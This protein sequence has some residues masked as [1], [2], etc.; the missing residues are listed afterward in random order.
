MAPSMITSDSTQPAFAKVPASL[1]EEYRQKLGTNLELTDAQRKRLT[2]WLK[3]SLDGWQRDT[4][5]LHQNLLD[6][7]DLVEG[8]VPETSFPWDGAS[9]VH[10]PITEMYMEIFE[11]VEKRSILGADLIWYAETDDED[12]KDVTADVEDAL[13]FKARN[14]WNICRSIEQVFPTTNRD[15]LGLLE[16]TWCEEYEKTHDIVLIT[17][18]DE[19]IQ[20][21]PDPESAGVTDEEYKRWA[22][23]SLAATDEEPMEIPITFE[24]EVYRG[25]K[26]EVVELINFVTIPATAPSIRHESCRGYGKRF[27]MRKETLRQKAKDGVLYKDAVERLI[28]SQQNDSGATDYLRAQDEIEGLERTNKD[29]FELFSLTI[30]GKLDGENDEEGERKF[31]VLYSL[32]K[33]ELIQCMEYPYRVDHYAEFRIDSRTN[34]LIGRSIPRKVRDLNDEI[35]TQ[36]NQR[37]NI[38]TISSVPSFK[39]QKTKKDVFDPEAEENKWRPGVVFWLDDFDT[40]EQFKVQPTDMGESLSEENNDLKILDMYLGSAAALLSGG[41]APGDPSAPGNKTAIMIQ[42]SNLRMDDPLSELR[43]GVNQV[44]DICLSH[45]YQFDRPLIDFQ[46]ERD[47]INGVDRETRTIHKKYL[48]RGIRMKMKGVTVVN[49]PDSEMQKMFQL[50]QQLMTEPTFQQNTEG[51]VQLLRDALRAG[52]VPGR[53]RYLPTPEELQQQMVDVQKQALQQME[54]EKAQAAA[55]QANQENQARIASAQNEIK[56]KDL[57]QKLAERSMAAA[58]A[59]AV[60]GATNGAA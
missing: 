2:T 24:K 28:K 38:R 51:R 40:F 42:Q 25:C 54:A 26:G 44:G 50:Y 7:N 49:N 5:E 32:K 12:L 53:Q 34:R 14:D 6:D 19:F 43:E 59:P 58:G 46:K 39:A 4:A 56:T 16:I 20:E 17:S 9:N 21:F 3:A 48:R 15:G 13:N 47:T 33:N 1:T 27:T 36:H 45:T 57:A 55:D 23:Q 60:N 37:I 18:P 41:T 10:A 52:R 30:K 29:A 31:M 8:V 11:S 22:Q 35:D